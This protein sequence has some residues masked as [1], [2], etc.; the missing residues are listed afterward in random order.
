[1][2]TYRLTSALS[3]PDYLITAMALARSARLY[4]FNLRHFQIM[5]GLDAQEPYARA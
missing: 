1:M 5:A 3:I 4:T 2:A